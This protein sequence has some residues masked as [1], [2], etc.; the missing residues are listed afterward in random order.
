[1]NIQKELID[2]NKDML[3]VMNKESRLTFEAKEL[4]KARIRLNDLIIKTIKNSKKLCQKQ[5]SL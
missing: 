5:I 4:L 3:L 2:N 1:M